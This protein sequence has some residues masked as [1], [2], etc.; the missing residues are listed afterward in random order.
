M[1]RDIHDGPFLRGR[2]PRNLVARLG[3]SFENRCQTIKYAAVG[4]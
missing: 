1:C 2:E 4:R 3:S